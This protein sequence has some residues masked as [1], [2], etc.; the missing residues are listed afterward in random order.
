MNKDQ[1]RAARKAMREWGYKQKL[2]E[3]DFYDIEGGVEGPYLKGYTTL[4]LN[5]LA[6]RDSADHGLKK[7]RTLRRFRDVADSEAELF[8]LSETNRGRYFRHATE[9]VAQ[10]YRELTLPGDVLNCWALYVQG[11]GGERFVA[12]LMGVG[13]TTVRRLL[14]DL[15]FN[16]GYRMRIEA[17]E[18]LDEEFE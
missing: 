1:R 13:R 4:S 10:A 18:D 3:T 17:R 11:D 14:R 5:G 9:I 2:E 15:R 12:D 8:N 7:D 16:I 6:N